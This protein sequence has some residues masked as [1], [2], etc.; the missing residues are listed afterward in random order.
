M[1]DGFEARL[2]KAQ[3]LD[4]VES[5]STIESEFKLFLC[6]KI[7]GVEAFRADNLILSCIRMRLDPEK[8]NNIVFINRNLK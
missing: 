1:K 7:V 2:A 8:F 4:I 5:K 6:K 3:R